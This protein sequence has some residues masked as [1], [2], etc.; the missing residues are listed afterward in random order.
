M[1]SSP[2]GQFQYQVKLESHKKIDGVRGREKE[3]H[4]V[5]GKP[6]SIGTFWLPKKWAS[7]GS[8][9]GGGGRKNLHPQSGSGGRARCVIPHDMFLRSV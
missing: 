9:P 1:A 4:Q 2:T 7:V 8:A 5:S 6:R 3:A